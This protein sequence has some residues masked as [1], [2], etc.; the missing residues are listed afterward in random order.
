MSKMTSRSWLDQAARRLQ[1]SG[2]PDARLDAEW[3]L[4]DALGIGRGELRLRLSDQIPA[5]ALDRA[6]AWLSAR[7]AG[8]PLQYVQRRA[9][10]MGHEFYVDERVLIPRQ[11]TELLCERAIALVRERGY[12]SALDLCSGSGA[13]GASMALACPGLRV[14]ASDI[15]EGALAV[16]ERNAQALGAKL[17]LLRGDL[18][19]TV[20]GRRFDLIVCNPPYIADVDMAALQPEVRREPELALRGGPDGLEFY[21]RIAGE[22]RDHLIPGGALLL[23]VG[24]GQAQAVAALLGACAFIERDLPGIE[25]VVGIII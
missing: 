6:E 19:G 23:E 2:A 20:Q 1:R 4:C 22:Y 16:A 8:A 25:R 17:E 7:E 11:D 21:R 15:S 5:T 3:M 12:A 10:L 13:V 9:Y 18:F 14:A 24:C